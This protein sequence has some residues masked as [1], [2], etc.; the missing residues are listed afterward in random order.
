LEGAR[1]GI[2]TLWTPRMARPAGTPLEIQG[3]RSSARPPTSSR[4][5]PD[6]SVTVIDSSP[7]CGGSSWTVAPL[8]RSRAFQ[9]SS[10]PAGTENDV[11]RICPAP[12]CPTGTPH[13]LYGKV[14]MMVPGAP[15]SLP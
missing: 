15:A 8:S 14:V 5:R 1:I 9:K 7:K 4:I 2:V 6:G 12:F 3:D 13:P 11:T 10:E